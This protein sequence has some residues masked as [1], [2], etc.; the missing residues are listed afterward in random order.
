MKLEALPSVEF[1]NA[2]SFRPVPETLT[3]EAP[4]FQRTNR[5]QQPIG[6]LTGRFNRVTGR[7][8]LSLDYLEGFDESGIVLQ[9]APVP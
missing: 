1:T 2:S 3:F 9:A 4:L 6:T 7:L 8:E 5:G